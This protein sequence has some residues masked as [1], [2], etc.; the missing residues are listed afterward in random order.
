MLELWNKISFAGRDK[1]AD[2]NDLRPLT[3]MNQVAA[4]AVLNLLAFIGVAFWFGLPHVAVYVSIGIVCCSAAI[5][6][7]S[8]GFFPVARIGFL[9]VSV[10]FV[11]MILLI[12]GKDAGSQVTFILIG[13]LHLVLFRSTRRALHVFAGVLVAFGLA[14]YLV[15]TQMKPLFVIEELNRF[16]FYLTITS[17][18]IL[19]FCVMLY[20]KRVNRTHEETIM[21]QNAEITQK[22]KD[23]TDSITYARRIQRAIFPPEAAVKKLLPESF[24]LY[25]PKDIVAGDFYWAE[26]AGGKIFFAVADCTGHGIP[27][28]LLSMLCGN[29]LSKAVKELD[30]HEPAKILDKAAQLL[31]EQFARSEEDVNDGMDIALCRFDPG[32]KMLQFAGANNT[33]CFIRNGE[34]HELPADK[35]PV[36]RHE[37]RRPFTNQTL[38]L[39]EGDCV[40]LFSDGFADQFGGPKGKKFKHSRFR[41]TLLDIHA[42]PMEKQKRQLEEIF[43]AWKGEL[44]QVD[45]VCVAGLRV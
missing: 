9:L 36:G 38:E 17:N 37:G 33:L 12:S 31:E 7:N 21:Q 20:F 34:A 41:Q 40:Y 28:A 26:S 30:I 23:I 43:E 19:V 39:R 42:L 45:D 8:R 10:A 24:V 32:K 44:E 6:L 27:G 14:S 29:A 15:E 2:P 16:S 11:C 5:W 4:I 22:N 25:R 13:V 18:M 1:L 35:Q 3:L